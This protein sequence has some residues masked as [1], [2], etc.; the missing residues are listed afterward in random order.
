MLGVTKLK[1]KNTPV[2][3]RS[4]VKEGLTQNSVSL[5]VNL[6]IL[7]RKQNQL[8]IAAMLLAITREFM[9]IFKLKNN[10]H[11]QNSI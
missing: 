2:A 9:M 11:I 4:C 1:D 5:L 6:A 10:N 7:S 8:S 3:T